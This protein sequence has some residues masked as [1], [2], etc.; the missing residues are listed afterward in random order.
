MGVTSDK[1]VRQPDQAGGKALTGTNVM[2][3]Y[4]AGCPSWRAALCL[5]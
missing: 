4:V 5:G 3:T 1:G 2:G